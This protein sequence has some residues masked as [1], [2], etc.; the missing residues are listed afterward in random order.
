MGSNSSKNANKAAPKLE[1]GRGRGRAS[2]TAVSHMTAPTGTSVNHVATPSR[3]SSTAV[4]RVVAPSQPSATAVSNVNSLA[5]APSQT[6]VSSSGAPAR[7]GATI[8]AASRRMEDLT[9]EPEDDYE[10]QE[11]EFSRTCG[12][13]LSMNGLDQRHNHLRATHPHGYRSVNIIII[14]I[15]L[16]DGLDI[17]G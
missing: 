17:R 6:A 5:A 11:S 14:L 13:L 7:A 12:T 15:K 10:E 3:A 4:S 1:R 8:N 2:A 16:S 9:P